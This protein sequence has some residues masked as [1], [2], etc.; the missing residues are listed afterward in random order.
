M[1]NFNQLNNRMEDKS[2]SC[3]ICKKN[4]KKKSYLSAHK[5]IHSDEKPYKCN[6]CDISFTQKGTLNINTCWY[7]VIR[8]S[9][10][11]MFAGNTLHKKII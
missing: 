8:K 5:R 2:I 6:A 1:Y 11:V 9:F 4:F 7:I 3:N 10:N